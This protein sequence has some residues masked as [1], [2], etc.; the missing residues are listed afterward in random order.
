MFIITPKSN[1]SLY[2]N[3]KIFQP[4]VFINTLDKLIKKAISNRLQVYSIASNFL[5]P[6]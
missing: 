2:D 3:P 5:H 6:N 4:I 1:K